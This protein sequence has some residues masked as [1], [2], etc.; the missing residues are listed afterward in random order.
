MGILEDFEEASYQVEGDLHLLAVLVLLHEPQMQ[1]LEIKHDFEN[2]GDL[3][4][5]NKYESAFERIILMK[6]VEIKTF[7]KA[8]TIQINGAM[9]RL[10]EGIYEKY[11]AVRPKCQKFISSNKPLR[12]E[13][14]VLFIDN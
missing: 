12:H 2:Y 11:K 8:Y 14:G 9:G 3:S 5:L 4:I 6:D 7:L 13:Q 10:R 1:Y